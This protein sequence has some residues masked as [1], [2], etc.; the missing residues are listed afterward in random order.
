M[1]GMMDFPAGNAVPRLLEDIK[2][3]KYCT[4]VE[5]AYIILPG[6]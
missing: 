1:P 6:L 5:M 3:M 4:G 2:R